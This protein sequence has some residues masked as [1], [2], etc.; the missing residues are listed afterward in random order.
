MN[1]TSTA[2]I[3]GSTAVNAATAQ[4]VDACMR[5]KVPYR[6]APN[7]IKAVLS[8][9]AMVSGPA[10]PVRHYGSVDMFLEALETAKKP[11]ILVIDNGGRTDE[12]CIGDL[13]VMEVKNA[14]YKGIVV[15]GLHR[16]TRDLLEIGLPVYSYGTCPSGPARLDSIEKEALESA[17]FGDFIVTGNDYVFADLDGVVFI[18]TAHLEPVLDLA[19]KIAQ[20]ER[21]QSHMVVEGK[22]LREQFD[23]Q[24]YLKT[25]AITENY[26][27]RLHLRSISKAIE[28]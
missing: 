2:D 22:S 12:A 20:Q 8:N 25:R 24:G 13:V 14:K 18:E 26:T 3:A 1:S 5:L 19:V 15:W 11:G 16:D 7:G 21:K 28:E 27:F 10:V 23:F 17:R 9:S 4:I 6:I